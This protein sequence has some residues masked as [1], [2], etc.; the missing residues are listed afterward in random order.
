[1]IVEYLKNVSGSIQLFDTSI[2]AKKLHEVKF[3]GD[4]HGSAYALVSNDPHDNFIFY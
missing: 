2:P 1:M 4:G 3:P